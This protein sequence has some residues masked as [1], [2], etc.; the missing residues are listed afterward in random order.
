MDRNLDPLTTHLVVADASRTDKTIC[1]A[2]TP[3]LKAHGIGGRARLF[4]VMQRVREVNAKRR[5]AASGYRFTGKSTDAIAL[6]KDLSLELDYI[7]APPRM[8][9]YMEVSTQIYN[10]YLKYIAAEDI[11]VYSIDE[12][13]ADI[14]DYL[15]IRHQSAHEFTMDIIHDVLHSTGITATAGIGTNMYLCKVAMDIVAKHIP[16][17]A[18]G[19]RIAELDELSYRKEL[20]S[21]EPLTDFWRVGRGT[22]EAL[23]PYG[24]RTMGQLARTSL[25]HEDFLY[26]LFGTNAELLID[27]A[28]GW[29]PCTMKEVKAYRPETR[30][31]SSGQ[32]LQ[33]PYEVTK[34]RIVV[35]EMADAIALDLV[36]KRMLTDAFELTIGYDRES[37]SNADVRMNYTGK[38]VVDHYGRQV[39]KPAHGT[40]HLPHPSSSSSRI[41]EAV[42]ALYDRIVNATFLIRRITLA[43]C[44]LQSETEI[45]CH[46]QIPRQL[47]LFSDAGQHSPEEDATTQAREHR[48]QQTMLDIRKTFGKNALLR[49]T[50]FE[51]GATA[52]ERNQQIGGHKA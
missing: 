3:S 51:E 37:L 24:I 30:S 31:I 25:T 36:S 14:T 44:H 48:M 18:D 38:I 5:R 29:E 34:A 35:R 45:A 17:D 41:T 22:A 27:H 20:W 1:L 32:V 19:V 10:I 8:A 26:N 43:A 11:H 28:W 46:P 47:D 16:A 2:V 23:A 7:I 40:T 52:I 39:P 4:E 6:Q 13:I 15:A 12:I 49:G 21:H 9:R 42:V 50:S 33:Q